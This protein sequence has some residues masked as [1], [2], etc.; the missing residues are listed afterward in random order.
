MPST[1]ELE[2]AVEPLEG[3]V[4]SVNSVD[5]DY[6]T[7]DEDEELQKLSSTLRKR[8]KKLPLQ[9]LKQVKQQGFNGTPL[10]R[11]LGLQDEKLINAWL[12]GANIVDLSNFSCYG[13][14]EVYMIN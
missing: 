13:Y 6:A 1:K 9:K 2:D 11:I 10:K 8:L 5:D 12:A 3:I 4:D 14:S 7:S